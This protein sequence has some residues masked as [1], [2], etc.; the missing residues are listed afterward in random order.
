VAQPDKPILHETELA[1]DARV[2]VKR[3]DYKGERGVITNSP[4]KF[5]TGWTV[6]LDSGRL[7]GAFGRDLKRV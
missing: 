7:F 6:R 5:F 3:G 4:G 1:V 2:Q